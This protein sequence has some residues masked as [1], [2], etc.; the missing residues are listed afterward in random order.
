VREQIVTKAHLENPITIFLPDGSQGR[1]W[2][3]S[4]VIGDEL[5]WRINVKA[6]IGVDQ[7]KLRFTEKPPATADHNPHGPTPRA[8]QGDD[9]P[10]E[11]Y[12][13]GYPKLPACL[14]R[15]ALPAMAEAA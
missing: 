15:R 9:Y 14:D 1:V 13:D 5:H 8:L 4:S 12:E 10:L 6:A 2:L 3:G 11:Y 7:D